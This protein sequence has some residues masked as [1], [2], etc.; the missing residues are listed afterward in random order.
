MNLL[1]YAVLTFAPAGSFIA[2]AKALEWRT[3]GNGATRSGAES[4]GLEVERLVGDLGRL[5]C[6]YCRIERSDLPRRAARLQ[7]V[8]LAYDDNLVR[9]L[10]GARDPVVGAPPVRRGSRSG[11]GGVP[12]AAWRHW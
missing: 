7:S 2:F 5:G 8:S 9:V 3:R 1:L 6:D 10:P 11:D 4:P 12:G